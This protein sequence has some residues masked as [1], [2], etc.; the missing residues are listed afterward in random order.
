LGNAL[1]WFTGTKLPSYADTNGFILIY[2]NTPNMLGCWDV[3]NKASLTHGQGGDALGIVSMVDYTID[4]YGAD[5]ARVYV[6][7]FSSG[8][9][10]TNV[11]AGSYPDVFE[12]AAAYSGVPDACFLGMF[13]LSTFN[14]PMFQLS[15][16]SI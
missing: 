13:P 16:P 6:M 14:Y 12:A 3:Y 8:A 1:Q 2:P 11:L 5:R 9:M 10:M 15:M 4:R 7:G